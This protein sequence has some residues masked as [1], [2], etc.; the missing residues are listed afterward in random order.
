MNKKI[1]VIV[2]G[3]CVQ[4]VILSGFSN[5]ELQ[6]IDVKII[7]FDDINE[8]LDLNNSDATKISNKSFLD[9]WEL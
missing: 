1:D 8:D 9:I 7:D 6:S 5:E 3:G 4:D 2:R